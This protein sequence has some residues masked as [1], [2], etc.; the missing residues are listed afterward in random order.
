MKP[1]VER[2][3][4]VTRIPESV[5]EKHLTLVL[6]IF[7][8]S[9]AFLSFCSGLYFSLS[10]IIELRG[11]EY[12]VVSTIQKYLSSG[13]PIYSYPSELPYQIS[14]YSPIYYLVVILFAK[15]LGISGEDYLSVFRLSRFL[16][17]GC[18]V[19]PYGLLFSLLKHHLKVRWSYSIIASSFLFVS[20]AP[21]VFLA[22]SD[23]LFLLVEILSVY[24]L[25]CGIQDSGL[26]REIFF[27]ASILSSFFSIFVKQSGIQ[28]LAIVLICFL[29]QKEFRRLLGYGA[30]LTVLCLISLLTGKVLENVVGNYILENIVDGVNNGIDILNFV[31]KTLVDFILPFSFVFPCSIYLTFKWF[32]IPFK[33]PEKVLIIFIYGYFLFASLFGLKY[34]SAENYY[35]EFLIFSVVA[36]TFY[37]DRILNKKIADNYEDESGQLEAKIDLRVAKLMG[38]WLLTLLITITPFIFVKNAPV[39]KNFLAS[40]GQLA[41]VQFLRDKVVDSDALIITED[42]YIIVSIPSHVIANQPVLVELAYLRNQVDFQ[43]LYDAV[44]STRSVYFADVGVPDSIYGINLE[45]DF[46]SLKEIDEYQ[47]LVNK[48]SV[49]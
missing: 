42:P 34:G 12:A 47:V 8:V 39:K 1:I 28:T 44:A 11:I 35:L 21:W 27:V 38:L 36:I 10:S 17:V 46:L 29:F 15:I 22:R 18:S 9:L 16:S 33:R 2:L 5:T 37:L 32:Y 41:V 40:E 23:S 26:N 25:L 6:V 30:L 45:D 13:T 20:L 19:I 4:G 7:T 31:R 24:F 43:E 14:Q 3:G 49:Q 48:K